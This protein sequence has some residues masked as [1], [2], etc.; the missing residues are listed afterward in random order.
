MRLSDVCDAIVDC[1]HKTA[2]VRD[3][4]ALSVGTRAMKDGRLVL[5]SC[6]P[7]SEKNVRQLD[8]PDVAASWRSRTSQRGSCGPGDSHSCTA[9]SASDNARF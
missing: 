6:K 1:E 2:P 3:G 8:T 9:V 7:V 4:F 5:E